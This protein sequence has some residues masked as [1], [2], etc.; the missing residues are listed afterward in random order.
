MGYAIPISDAQ[1]IIEE[2]MS[3]ET[4]LKVNED[5]KGYLGITGVN[6]YQE[7]AQIYGIPEGVYV[8]S[9]MEGTGAEAAGLQIGDIITALNEEEI[10]SMDELKDE[11]AYYEEGETVNLTIMR[12]GT[13]GYETLVVEITLGEQQTIQ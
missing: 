10:S 1:P 12:A 7:Y 4:R 5:K 8:S 6:V 2:L 11:L 9:V 3:K 13:L